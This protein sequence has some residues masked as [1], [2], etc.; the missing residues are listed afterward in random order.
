MTDAPLLHLADDA[1]TLK[2]LNVNHQRNKAQDQTS[3]I[4]AAAAAFRYAD[5]ARQ[6]W[7]PEGFSLLW[8]TPVWDAAD[9]RQRVLLNQMY[10]V[11]YYAQIVSAEVATIFYNQTSAAGLYALEDF[12]PVC[13]TL[14]FE[15]AQERAHIAAFRT[16]AGQ[17]EDALLGRRV[18]TWPMRGPFEETMIYADAGPFR[19]W[20]KRLQLRTYGLLSSGNA[21]IGCQYFLVRGLRT[22]NGKQV[23]H[24]LS[25]HHQHAADPDAS[26]IPSQ[27]SYAHFL[28]ESFHF[29]SSTI[30]SHD[31]VRC[32][33][34]PTAFERWVVN[35]SLAGC[36][37][38]HRSFSAA[39]NGI[40][41]H[42][43]ALYD[44]LHAVLASPGYGLSD[45]DALELLRRTFTNESEGVHASAAT[46]A[47]ARDSYR[48]YLDGLPFIDAVNLEQRITGKA[49]VVDWLSTNRRAFAAWEARR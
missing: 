49:S 48:T 7:N 15:S 23:Q 32:L 44:D 24:Q 36:Q 41:W 37:R 39:I 17:T 12:R 28:D 46:H 45:R 34:A 10:W 14:D 26:P 6:P 1:R 18:F 19:R 31:V 38:D 35:L 9:A 5:C 27:V 33:K 20:W 29:N 16:I 25:Q 4:D 43:P 22:L 13:D 30:I 3:V 40:F 11:A 42:D 2:K 8:G 21:F 47:K